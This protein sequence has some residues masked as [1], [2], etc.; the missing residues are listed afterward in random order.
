MAT[1]TEAVRA[2]TPDCAWPSME[3]V[4][5]GARRVRRAY[6]DTKQKVEDST[7]EA[8]LAVR[9]RPLASV[10]AGIGVGACLGAVCGLIVAW[11]ARTR[12]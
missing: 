3:A 1:A 12:C 10:A 2:V 7:A 5:E 6:T 11:S 8:R 9:R 4:E